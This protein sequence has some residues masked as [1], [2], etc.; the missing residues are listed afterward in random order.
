MSRIW[1]ALCS[2][3][4]WYAAAGKITGELRSIQVEI[5]II[6]IVLFKC[7]LNKILNEFWVVSI[8]RRPTVFCVDKVVRILR[9]IEDGPACEEV[10]AEWKEMISRR[11]RV[12]G[13]AL[14]ME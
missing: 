1:Y 10:V 13:E 14:I 11:G 4:I 9:G 3:N 12:A 7:G 2:D 5:Q 6:G 8:G